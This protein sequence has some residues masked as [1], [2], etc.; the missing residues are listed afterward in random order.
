MVVKQLCYLAAVYYELQYKL[1]NKL[2]VGNSFW[3]LEN[4][5]FIYECYTSCE[6][7]YNVM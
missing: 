4:T 3:Q 1:F 7:L 2:F 6:Q 5:L